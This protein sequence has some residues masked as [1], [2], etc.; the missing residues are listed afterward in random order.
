[1][2]LRLLMTDHLTVNIFKPERRG[3]LVPQADL[4]LIF[5]ELH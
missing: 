1:M 5:S 4:A 2:A 3:P